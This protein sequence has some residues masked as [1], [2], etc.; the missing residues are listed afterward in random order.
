MPLEEERATAAV[1]MPKN[2]MKFGCV[3]SEICEQTV[4][5]TDSV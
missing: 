3:V 2:L 5:Q 4:R 1:N